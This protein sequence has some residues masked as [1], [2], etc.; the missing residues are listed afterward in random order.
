M[1]VIIHPYAY[2]WE[3]L[4]TYAYTL[5]AEHYESND[6]ATSASVRR[7]A[8]VISA[9]KHVLARVATAVNKDPNF[10]EELESTGSGEGQWTLLGHPGSPPSS[11]LNT[12]EQNHTMRA[13]S[14]PRRC[15]KCVSPLLPHPVLPAHAGQITGRYLLFPEGLRTSLHR[16]TRMW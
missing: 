8:F 7:L 2:T 4:H 9:S 1:P 13:V 16:G 3:I 14:A 6:E 15:K 5:R 10:P 11:I 12:I